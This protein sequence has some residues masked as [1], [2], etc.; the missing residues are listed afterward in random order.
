MVVRRSLLAAAGLVLVGCG[1]GSSRHAG[2][3]HGLVTTPLVHYALPASVA[4]PATWRFLPNEHV[5]QGPAWTVGYL[6]TEPD[7]SGC[8][9]THY[10]S[11][12][13]VGVVCH[14]PVSVLRPG[15]VLVLIGAWAAEL[16]GTSVAANT[17]VDGRSVQID[18][19]DPAICP[20]GSTGSERLQTELHDPSSSPQNGKHGFSIQVCFNSTRTQENLAADADRVIRGIQFD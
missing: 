11:N 16:S 4:H 14:G 8:K 1:S 9:T 18:S 20:A 7:H 12:N 2:V 19:G 17:T 13:T 3:P 6:T 5:G 10:R 15:G